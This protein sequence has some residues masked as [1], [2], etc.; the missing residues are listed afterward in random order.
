VPRGGSVIVQSQR[1]S[2]RSSPQELDW[3]TPSFYSTCQTL[4]S[5]STFVPSF[6]PSRGQGLRG[7]E[8][9]GLL[10]W[11]MIGREGCASKSVW[12]VVVASCCQHGAAAAWHFTRIVLYKP[13]AKSDRKKS[14][15]LQPLFF[16]S[17]TLTP[18]YSTRVQYE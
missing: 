2:E 6:L 16:R 3:V 11:G 1:N 14:G 5:A 8:G 4:E 12:L 7:G 9:D 18:W 13:G 17:L 15:W 10:G